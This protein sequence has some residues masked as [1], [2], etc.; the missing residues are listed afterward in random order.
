M[1]WH[2]GLGAVWEKRRRGRGSRLIL[3]MELSLAR[4]YTGV[5]DLRFGGVVQG[6]P[7]VGV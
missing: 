7:L 2:S 4:F 1:T 5:T 6:A 3:D